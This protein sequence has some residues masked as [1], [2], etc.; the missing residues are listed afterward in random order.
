MPAQDIFQ[1]FSQSGGQFFCPPDVFLAKAA[2]IKALIWDWDGVFNNGEKLGDQGSPFSE[3]DSM[4]T[5]LLRFALHQKNGSMPLAGIITGANN[6]T[7]V[8][9]AEREHLQFLFLNYKNKKEALAHLVQD[10]GLK[11][12]EVAFFFD[13]VLDL[14]LAQEVGLRIQIADPSKVLFNQAVEAN[15]WADYRT[16]QVGGHGGLREASELVAAAIGVDFTAL[17]RHRLDWSA[18]YASYFAERQAL[19]TQ[20]IAP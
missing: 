3:V 2:T 14:P 20:V 7:A 15:N 19:S 12:S 9:F 1:L 6:Q 17:L 11:P 10:R 4:G 16:A 18:T 13:D 5:N 8:S